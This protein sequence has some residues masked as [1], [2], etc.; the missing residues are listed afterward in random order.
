MH[1][2][3]LLA[4]I[5]ETLEDPFLADAL[6]FDAERHYVGRP[7]GGIMQIY[8]EYHHGKDMWEIQVSLT[9]YMMVYLHGFEGEHWPELVS[10][11]NLYLF[12]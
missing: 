4:T 12:G 8:Q 7:G 9:R 2:R 6:V 5:R 11:S 10:P 1:S 3:D